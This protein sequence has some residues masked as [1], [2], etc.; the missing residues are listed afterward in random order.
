MVDG[1]DVMGD[2]EHVGRAV[3]A[4]VDGGVE[5]PIIFPLPWGEDRSAVVRRTLQAAI[6]G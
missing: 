1:I 3:Q 2:A 6:G 4:Y 5:V